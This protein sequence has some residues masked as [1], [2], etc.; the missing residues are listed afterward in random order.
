[1]MGVRFYLMVLHYYHEIDDHEVLEVIDEV[2]VLID[3]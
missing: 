1:M 3:I 2:I